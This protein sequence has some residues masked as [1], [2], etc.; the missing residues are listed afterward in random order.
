MHYD[1]GYITLFCKLFTIITLCIAILPI[2][3]LF[4]IVILVCVCVLVVGGGGS[5]DV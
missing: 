2:D 5:I 1:S 3:L 4:C